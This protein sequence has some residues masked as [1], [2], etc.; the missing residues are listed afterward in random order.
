V[1]EKSKKER[2]LKEVYKREKASRKRIDDPEAT[3]RANVVKELERA[4]HLKDRR[5]FLEAIRTAGISDGSERFRQI[6]E[7]YDRMHSRW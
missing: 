4:F 7:L 2:D 3:K 1:D 5:K 6:V